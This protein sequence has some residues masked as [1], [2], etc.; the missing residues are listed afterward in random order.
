MFRSLVQNAPDALMVITDDLT[1]SYANPSVERILDRKVGELEGCKVSEFM[2]SSMFDESP[3]NTDPTGNEF[4][5]FK[6]RHG[7]GSW[8]CLEARSTDLL[9][10]PEVQGRAY[11]IRDITGLRVTEEESANHDF[12]N[13]LTGLANRPLFMDRLDHALGG[14]ARSG[15]PVSILFLDLDDFEI[16]NGD[17]GRSVGDHL[18][19]MV[20]QRLRGSLRPSDTISRFGG[21]KFAVLF[22][23]PASTKNA[24]GVAERISEALREPISWKGNTLLTTASVGVATSSSR[25]SMSGD[26][27][28]AA[29]SAMHE[30]K[31]G[32]KARYEVFRDDMS[33]EISG[34]LRLEDDLRGAMEREEFEVHYQPEVCLNTGQ[35][36]GLEALLRWRHPERGFVPPLEFVP[37]AEENGL[38][39]PIGRWVLHEACRQA[40]LWHER[41]LDAP[42]TVSVNLSARQLRQPSLAQ[43]V[44]TVLKETGLPPGCLILEVTESLL[45]EGKERPNDTLHR[46]KNLGVRIAIDDFGTG[47]SSLSYIDRLP[48]DILKIDYSFVRGLRPADSEPPVLIPLLIDLAQKLGAITI[49]EGIENAEQLEQLR[50]MG[51]DVGQG[52]YLSEPLT[53]SAAFEFLEADPGY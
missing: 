24:A 39:V 41:V 52:N 7:D 3:R 18:L 36:F 31:E 21:D 44:A 16:I 37:V 10:D 40:L 26:L 5:W 35:V 11:Y 25:L 32:G 33:V 46:L 48:M 8:R 34:S 17:F 20:T 38:I 42:P 4:V 27:L 15:G 50:S 23:E 30:A 6:L 1:V 2:D 53:S 49:A 9:D 14:V 19:T 29:E 22:G 43:T 51:C 28:N 47:Y 12:Y 45:V 13:S